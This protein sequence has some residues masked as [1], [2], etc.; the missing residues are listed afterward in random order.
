MFKL[1]NF[2]NIQTLNNHTGLEMAGG[3]E[4]FLKY[5]DETLPYTLINCIGFIVGSFGNILIMGAIII[6][7]ELHNE[8]SILIFNLSLAELVITGFV[9]LF[10]ILGNFIFT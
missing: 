3:I 1:N 2:T 10:T 9:N 6:T 5:L 4:Y 8:T 7:K